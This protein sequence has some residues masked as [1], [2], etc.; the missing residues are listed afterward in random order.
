MMKKKQKQ[1]GDGSRLFLR[2]AERGD[3]AMQQIVGRPS[4]VDAGAQGRAEVLGFVLGRFGERREN[5]ARR[6]RSP[7]ASAASM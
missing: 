7:W 3:R 4:G 1:H 6:A 5:G 2:C